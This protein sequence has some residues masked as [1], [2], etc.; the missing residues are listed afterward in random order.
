M[1]RQSPPRRGAAVLLAALLSLSAPV[2]AQ[3]PSLEDALESALALAADS[4]RLAPEDGGDW[5]SGLP[6]LTVA[7]YDSREQLGTDEAEAILNFPLKGTARR[8]L[9]GELQEL[10]A[11]LAA[12]GE[13]HRRWVY[14]GLV[15][16]RAWGVRL[17]D[18][19]LAAAGEK[20]TLLEGLEARIARLAEQGVVPEY[21]SLIVRQ[22][23][24][25]AALES[26]VLASERDAERLAF[27]ALTGLQTVPTDLSE[28]VAP[29]QAPDW[30]NHP[31]LRMQQL[32]RAQEQQLLA[33]DA[34]AIGNWNLGLVA[35]NFDGPEFTDRQFGVSLEVPLGFTEVRSAGNVST[36]RWAER[37]FRLE[38]D[39]LMLAVREEWQTLQAEAA[40]LQRRR[41]I[42]SEAE[43][44]TV[45]IE[46]QLSR[47]KANNEMEAEILLQRMLNVIETRAEARMTDALIGRN[48]ARLRQAAGR[49]L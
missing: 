15:R 10:D 5:L 48:E 13:A 24:L 9:D 39:R 8:R 45:R 36:R 12:A 38:R 42:L 16:E 18:L 34:P 21:R 25:E 17:A 6:S 20:R 22:S 37:T 31:A 19:R 43:E 1:I 30:A 2:G 40:L 46:S 49:S 41:E 3:E 44:L 4:E 47:L 7:Y 29:P 26:A 35:R 28:P 27:A 11:E 14:S 23:L 32:T 33:L